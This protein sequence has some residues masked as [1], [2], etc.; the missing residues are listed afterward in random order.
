MN[1]A[2]ET[3]HYARRRRR[4]QGSAVLAVNAQTLTALALIALAAYVGLVVDV[5]QSDTAEIVR[6]APR[7]AQP[8]GGGLRE[9]RRFVLQWAQCPRRRPSRDTVYAASR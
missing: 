3:A 6:R 2:A 8:R 1:S 9:A 4:A 7:R 5:E